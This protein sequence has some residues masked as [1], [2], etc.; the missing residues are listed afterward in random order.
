M[1]SDHEEDLFDEENVP[2]IN[3]YDVLNIAKTASADE[4]KSAY[5]KAALKNHPGKSTD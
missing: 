2:S 3:P 1:S 4:V 5:R